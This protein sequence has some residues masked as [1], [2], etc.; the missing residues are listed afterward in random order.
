MESLCKKEPKPAK[1]H[2]IQA[3]QFDLHCKSHLS[4]HH[5]IQTDCDYK[6]MSSRHSQYWV[7]AYVVPF[8]QPIYR[9]SIVS[10]DKKNSVRYSQEELHLIFFVLHCFNSGQ[11]S[12]ASMTMI[13]TLME[14]FVMVL[15]HPLPNMWRVAITYCLRFTDIWNYLL[16]TCQQNLKCPFVVGW[17]YFN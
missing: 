12:I 1:F 13:K 15:Q 11:Y 3:I 5:F 10:I 7:I 16:K 9:Q 6:T 8:Q 2:H 14:K 17:W 4:Q